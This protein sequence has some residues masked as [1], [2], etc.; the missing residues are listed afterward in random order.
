MELEV[1]PLLSDD[2]RL[3]GMWG[4]CR[5]SEDSDG[6]AYLNC[7]ERDAYAR[8]TSPTRRR[9]WLAAR[10]IIKEI[11]VRASLIA[12]F[13]ECSVQKDTCGCPRILIH[14]ELAGN[15]HCTI[16][17]KNG[18]ALSAVSFENT[19]FLGVDLERVTDKPLL[20][21]KAFS[22]GADFIAGAHSLR[23]KYCILW[24][25]KE[26][27]SKAL[28]KGMAMD[29]KKIIIRATPQETYQARGNKTCR[30]VGRYAAGKD[31]VL[32]ICHIFPAREPG[33]KIHFQSCQRASLMTLLGRRQRRSEQ[34]DCPQNNKRPLQG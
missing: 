17:H 29:F 28:G 11:M 6:K 8:L 30:I 20:L 25:C 14:E 22:T 32:S 10:I 7:G 9:E 26:A 13:Q 34:K 16:T 21:R 1:K 19:L 15:C 12:S 24:S 31:R 3:T 18:L 33:Y 2:H 5:V 27:V 23:E 4:W